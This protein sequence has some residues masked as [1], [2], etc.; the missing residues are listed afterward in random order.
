MVCSDLSANDAL[1]T[2][3]GILTNNDAP[4]GYPGI[5]T[6]NARPSPRCCAT[7]AT[8]HV[9]RENGILRPRCTSRTMRGRRAAASTA[10]SARSLAAAAST[11]QERSPAAK[12]TFAR[13]AGL[14]IVS[15]LTRSLPKQWTSPRIRRAQISSTHQHQPHRLSRRLGLTLQDG[16]E[17]TCAR[18]DRAPNYFFRH[19]IFSQG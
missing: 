16:Y 15:T 1:Q 7:L 10:S 14:R 8:R 6:S 5:S 4:N 18:V 17:R 3:I 12:A 2:G 9:F 11:R 19:A 13:K